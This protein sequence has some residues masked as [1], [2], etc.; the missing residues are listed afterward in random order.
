MATMSESITPTSPAQDSGTPAA[1]TTAVDAET[2]QRA[3]F[4]TRWTAISSALV[5]LLC[6]LALILVPIPFVARSPGQ[7]VNLLSTNEQG[8]PMIQIDGLTTRHSE[9]EMRMTT[10]STTRADSRLS[11]AEALVDHIRQDHDV[12]QREAIYPPGRS[13][14]QVNAEESY[15]MDT[16]QRDA[17]VAAL[18]A[19]GQPVVEMPMVNAVS[20]V[21]PAH[22][23]LE[24]GD[25]IEKVDGKPVSSLLDVGKA[26]RKHAVGDTMVFGVLR[27]S[28]SRTVAVTTVSS[29]SDRR[30]PAVGIT[31]DTG[32]R[33]AP[34]VNYGI[35]AD[36]VGP[37]AGLAMALSIYQMVA[38]N[39]L[40]GS[41]R[42]AST[43]S[44]SPDGNVVAIGGI[45]EKIAGAERDGAK[46]FLVPAGNCRDVSGVRTS[47]RLVKVSNLKDAIA[48]IQKIRSGGTGV[49]H[50]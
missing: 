26:L 8:K 10:V 31:V 9:G 6:V 30:A 4:P 37:S 40:I 21:G 3:R 7:T 13:P 16:S 11:L 29:V 24:P 46:I 49:P 2:R 23:K 18:R 39:D 41:L 36:I 14:Q 20:A 25:L 50:C 28:T 32:Y 43:G 33:Y 5:V 42:I 27:N 34:T 17:A 44:I 19:A 45:Q 1:T 35:P 48:V 12:L 22:G 15:M 47:M 38:P